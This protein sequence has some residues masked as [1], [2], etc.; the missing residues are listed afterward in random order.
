MKL[1]HLI[2]LLLISPAIFAEDLSIEAQELFKYLPQSKQQLEWEGSSFDPLRIEFTTPKEKKTL[3]SEEQG[4]INAIKAEIQNRGIRGIVYGRGA[5]ESKLLLGGHV[6]STADEIQFV[7]NQGDWHPIHEGR[8]VIL[9][10]IGEGKGVFLVSGKGSDIVGP[11]EGVPF[12]VV[13]ED[14]FKDK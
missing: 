4:H 12:E 6:F 5:S 8:S 1:I 14:F 7:D 11:E 13:W 2:A 3:S 9:L 10:E